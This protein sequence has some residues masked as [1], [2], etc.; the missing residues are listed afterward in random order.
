MRTINLPEAFARHFIGFDPLIR[1][2]E[3]VSDSTFPPHNIEQISENEYQ[4]TLAIAGYSKKEVNISLQD[5][6]LT[7]SG[8]KPAPKTE[9]QYLYHGIAFRE[10]SRNFRIGENVEVIN[11]A[12]E[13]GLL[14]IDLERHI[15]EEQ[16]PK[17]IKI[18]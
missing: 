1:F 18:T 5:G 14:V 16:K 13:N 9:P 8:S 10:F 11:A 6:I 7:I 2:S 4:L 15:P 12:L 3:T 17:A